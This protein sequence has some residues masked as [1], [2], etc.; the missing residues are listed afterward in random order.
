[1]HIRENFKTKKLFQSL[2][3][4]RTV[5]FCEV[6]FSYLLNSILPP[7]DAIENVRLKPPSKIKPENINIHHIKFYRYRVMLALNDD[8]EKTN[9][10][11]YC[12]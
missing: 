12:L 7:F 10:N 9:Y 1:M 2:L 6:V 8:S 4:G 11:E 5:L 3:M